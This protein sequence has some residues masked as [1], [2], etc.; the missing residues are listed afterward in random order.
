[1]EHDKLVGA[2]KLRF[3]TLSLPLFTPPE[4]PRTC[5]RI[6]DLFGGEPVG[7]GY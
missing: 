1:M 2:L 6:F 7:C 5:R 4:R 3:W